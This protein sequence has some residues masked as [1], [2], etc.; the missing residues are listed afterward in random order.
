MR[1]A[2]NRIDVHNPS[3]EPERQ[4]YAVRHKLHG[5]WWNR[6]P[7][8]H[9][10]SHRGRATAVG[11]MVEGSQGQSGGL[12]SMTDLTTTAIIAHTVVALTTLAALLLLDRRFDGA[13]VSTWLMRALFALTAA[14][15]P[16]VVVVA[17]AVWVATRIGLCGCEEGP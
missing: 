2:L 16:L 5:W 6:H 12:T 14:L 17:L 1:Q 4:G 7:R 10:T 13:S 15:W 3:I 11:R 9:R 8:T